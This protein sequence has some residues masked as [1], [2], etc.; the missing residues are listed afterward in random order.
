MLYMDNDQTLGVKRYS[1]FAF[2]NWIPISTHTRSSTVAVFAKHSHI[3]KYVVLKQSL[4][5][6]T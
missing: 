4:S 5:S 1:K 2:S 3:P 6:N